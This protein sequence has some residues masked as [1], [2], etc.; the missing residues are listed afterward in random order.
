MRTCVLAALLCIVLAACE[1]VQRLFTGQRVR[2]YRKG[3]LQFARHI[4]DVTSC[5]SS[6]SS[7]ARSQ[8][9]SNSP[10]LDA[11][12]KYKWFSQAECRKWAVASIAATP[13]AAVV[14][15][16]A[17]L[18]SAGWC[19]LVV[20]D[21]GD[22]PSAE[23]SMRLSTGVLLTVAMQEELAAVSPFIAQL[24][25]RHISRKN[26]GYLIAI[27]HGA[28]AVW[29]ISDASLVNELSASTAAH[30]QWLLDECK[31]C[32]MPAQQLCDGTVL[33]HGVFAGTHA[34]YNA[35]SDMASCS[36]KLQVSVI[37]SYAIKCAVLTVLLRT[38][39][40]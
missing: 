25:W 2:S 38:C 31:N 12:S 7:Q 22:P 20:A 11:L 1:G 9:E 14:Q 6:T 33:Q 39:L 15:A 28:H 32:S 40:H 36:V 35:T 24:P 37:A 30:V 29:D 8:H 13:I 16:A 19:L 3:Q 21:K 18:N 17:A 5:N 23:Y 10:L 4:Q 26:V 34:A 27:L